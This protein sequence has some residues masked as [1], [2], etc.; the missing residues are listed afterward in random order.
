[1]VRET[2]LAELEAKADERCGALR[3][4]VMEARG[5]VT[6]RDEA[7]L[8]SWRAVEM[9]RL[10]A[11]ATLEKSG[12]MDRYV[13]GRQYVTRENKALGQMLKAATAGAKLLD[14]LLPLK[15]TKAAEEAG[16]ADGAGGSLDDY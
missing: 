5:E 2:L 13:S 11:A 12:L 7:L 4:R 1:M 15:R 3:A 6:A 8:A 10:E 16:E 14:A 9:A